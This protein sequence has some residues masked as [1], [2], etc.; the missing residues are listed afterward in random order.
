MTQPSSPAIDLQATT[1][2][3]EVLHALARLG[4]HPYAG[5]EV[6][7]DYRLRAGLPETLRGRGLALRRVLYAAIESLKPADGVSEDEGAFVY[8]LLEKRYIR[9]QSPDAVAGQLLLGR[10]TFFR[11]QRKAL[12][13]LTDVLWEMEEAHAGP[14]PATM[15]VIPRR[16]G[17]VGRLAE[18][19][20]YEHFLTVDHAILISG[21]FGAG[22][23]TVAAEIAGRRQEMGDVIWITLRLGMN[24]D[25]DMLLREIGLHLVELGHEEHARVLLTEGET[26]RA[27]PT[28]VRVSYLLSALEQSNV[29]LC[30]DNIELVSDNPPLLGLLRALWERARGQGRFSLMVVGR[31]RPSFTPAAHQPSLEGLTDADARRLVVP[32]GLAW[33]PELLWRQCYAVT[34]GN[35]MLLE[36]LATC[37]SHTGLVPGTPEAEAAVERL[38]E[39][40]WRAPDIADYLLSQVYETLDADA[41]RFMEV[42][43]AFRE[44]FDEEDA[45]VIA[46]LAAEGVRNIRRCLDTLLRFHLA[47]RLTGQWATTFHPVI[48]GYFYSRLKGQFDTKQRVHRNIARYYAE[49]KRNY[50][51]ALYHWYE[52]GEYDQAAQL[53]VARMDTL[54]YLGQGRRVLEV[55]D[56]FAPQQVATAVWPLV[57]Q[58]RGDA[59]AFT[60]DVE[61]AVRVYTA[62]LDELAQE[63]AGEWRQTRMATLCHKVGRSLRSADLRDAMHWYRRGLAALDGKDS[64]AAAGIYI[65]G[66]GVLYQQANY[67]ESLAWCRK[68]LALL[69]ASAPLFWQA[70]GENILGNSYYSQGQFDAAMHHYQQAL[71]VSRE[72]GDTFHMAMS[73][74]NL[75]NT[76]LAQGEWNEALRLYEASAALKEAAG[77]VMGLAVTLFNLGSLS[78]LRGEDDAALDQFN[79]CM[80]IWTRTQSQY[81]MGA[82][83]MNLGWLYLERGELAQAQQH[84][85]HS[86][87]IFRRVQGRQYW[88]EIFRLAAQLRLQQGRPGPARRWAARSLALGRRL[89]MQREIMMTCLVSGQIHRALGQWGAAH[90][91]LRRSLRLAQ[92][93]KDRYEDGVARIETARLRLAEAAEDGETA[94][95]RA[96]AIADL[97]QAIT[98]LTPLAAARDLRRARELLANLDADGGDAPD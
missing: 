22:K 96:A 14:S 71:A 23:T 10:A 89:S 69:D 83:H 53:V 84:V 61:G 88:P 9:Q 64:G 90:A 76:Y 35:P 82:T 46:I 93:L 15:D 13:R 77:N 98:L 38:L 78:A 95:P 59:L 41:Q 21:L 28:A 86:L 52:A 42:A 63:P 27:Q 32:L 92:Q 94:A 45:G 40:V 33:L 66:A 81:G 80:D 24:T 8:N 65:D 30:L 50:A 6:V 47:H 58:A 36:L 75:A 68:G 51:E 20:D 74:S 91:V 1:Q 2:T 18:L 5:L 67:S 54:L 39:A 62:L 48:R 60:G 29:C 25:I 72:T 44:P 79:R 70:Q 55:L 19:A 3:L 43:S 56:R 12:Q 57:E 4:A 31:I 97:R 34:R 85:T 26:R 16:S 7:K 73:Y 17:F 11:E 49:S 87:T 37:V